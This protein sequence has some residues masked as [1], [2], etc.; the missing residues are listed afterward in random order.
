[1]ESTPNAIPEE[2]EGSGLTAPGESEGSESA[3]VQPLGD[4]DATAQDP[5]QM[6]PAQAEWDRMAALD[7]GAPADE[8]DSATGGD[9][10]EI[11]D[12]GDEIPAE[13]L[14]SSESQPETQGEDP[15]IAELGEEGEGDLTPEDL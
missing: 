5:S 9:P 11:P 2:A 8:S 13:D 1:M 3:P 10:A 15:V 6:D 7:G 14:P 12:A 4:E